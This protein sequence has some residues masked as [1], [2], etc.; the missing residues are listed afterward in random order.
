MICFQTRCR[1]LIAAAGMAAAGAHAADAPGALAVV[2]EL[3]RSGATRLALQRLE[4]LQPPAAAPPAG[5]AAANA[6]WRDWERL[7]L[8]LLSASGQSEALLRRAAQWRGDTADGELHEMAARAALALGRGAAAREHAARALW[9]AG[10]AEPRLRE[11]RLLVINSLL[12]DRLADDAYRSMLR[13]QQ[14]YRPLDAAAATLFVD[15]L[16]DLGRAADAVQWLGLLD[17]RGAARLR[18]RLHAGV[19]PPAEAA[20]QARAALNRSDD[21]AW[22]RI[23]AEAAQRLPSPLL[24]IEAAETG[25]DRVRPDR[26]ANAADQLWQDYVAYARAAANG[27]QLLAGDEAGWFEFARRRLAAE[28]VLARAYLGLLAREAAADKI[29]RAAQ[30]ALVASLVESRQPRTALRLF[31]GWRGGP[32]ALDGDARLALATL[33]ENGGDHA[34]ALEYRRGL[35]ALSGTPPAVW[36]LRLLATAL[37]A[38]QYEAATAVAR[39]LAES[40]TAPAP[41][42][43]WLAA[44]LQCAD[45]GAFEASQLLAERV[46][47]QADAAQA[48]GILNALAEGF[49]RASQPQFAA[50][51][52]LRVAARAGDGEAAAA[53]RLQAGLQLARAGLR[54]DARAQFDWVL[55][56]ARDPAQI[57]LARREL[58]F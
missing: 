50:D 22:W 14:D 32:E 58:G 37:R 49:A 17:E 57:A 29:R 7:R 33:A 27:H 28:P 5:S 52:F 25:L 4:V 15:G 35:A 21:A 53:A 9:P 47:P 31:S 56:N 24:G 18:L 36:Q 48:R 34:R 19:V 38:G 40:G 42:E 2:Q 8:Q 1:L 41:L 12:A 44:V 10:V 6:H 16:L 45:H 54:D 23:L 11:L 20:T 43:E 26:A 39:A 51:Y 55:K 3:A 30:A 13:F 46:L